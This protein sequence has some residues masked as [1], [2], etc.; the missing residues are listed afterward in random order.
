ML[1]VA[2][3]TDQKLDATVL[4]IIK[5]YIWWVLFMNWNQQLSQKKLFT[6]I[7]FLKEGR[8]ALM[9]FG[10]SSRWPGITPRPRAITLPPP[11]RSCRIKNCLF[12]ASSSFRTAHSLWARWPPK[13]P[14]IYYTGAVCT[15]TCNRSRP[16]AHVFS[17]PAAPVSGLFNSIPQA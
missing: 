9:Q 1:A 11:P 7:N 2:P 15:C 13:T 8:E 10:L 16:P 17:L 12:P 4:K 5:V 3:N 14:W 6:P